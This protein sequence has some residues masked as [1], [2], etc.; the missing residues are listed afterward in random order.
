[1]TATAALLASVAWGVA[2]FLGG[3]KSRVVPTIVVL[4]LA[5]VSGL[6][7]I[8]LV[9]AI[10]GNAPPGASIL[11][12]SLAGVFGTVGLA[13]FYRGMAVGSIS[14]V[15]P[16]AAI[17]AVVPVVFGIATGDE[18]SR[19]Q[20]LGFVL[21]L[22]GVAL[23]SFERQETGQARLAAGVPWA[24]AAVIG[25][26]GYYVP[27]H[28]ASEQDFL[29]A[30]LVFRS[31][32]AVLAFAAW[33]VLRPPLRA[34][35]G[36]LGAIAMIG[37]LDTAGNTLFAAAASLGEVSVVSVLATLYPVTTVALAAI[38]LSERIDRLQLV[39]VAAALTGVV[40]ISAA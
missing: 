11:W 25:F 36:H 1:M 7:G 19:L 35:R 17:G 13:S 26:G 33:L 3:L 8:G 2:D 22:S 12:A 4:L 38:V 27:M 15:A 23:A 10:A 31:T 18:V 20:I 37:I 9:V 28:E 14:I 29:W 21:A 5:Q 30:A 39:G 6:L 40:L 34:A 24:I 32:V 16:I